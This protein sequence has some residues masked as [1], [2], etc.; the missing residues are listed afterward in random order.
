MYV[1]SGFICFIWIHG[2]HVNFIEYR[3]KKKTLNHFYSLK[4]WGFLRLWPQLGIFKLILEGKGICSTGFRLF[5][6]FCWPCSVVVH[7]FCFENTWDRQQ[8]KISEKAA[9]V[10]AWLYLKD[11]QCPYTLT[12]LFLE[13]WVRDVYAKTG[14]VVLC[15]NAVVSV[16]VCWHNPYKGFSDVASLK[17]NCTKVHVMHRAL[18]EQLVVARI[19]TEK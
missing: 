4:Y 7:P 1:S 2:M 8:G 18:T 13:I 3:E 11:S 9:S 19:S 15:Q 16:K 17:Q 6:S 5:F 10:F 12:M 14:F